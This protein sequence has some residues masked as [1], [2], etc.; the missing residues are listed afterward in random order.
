MVSK[1][2][3]GWAR[4]CGTALTGAAVACGSAQGGGST[5]W[6]PPAGFYDSVSGTG[7]AL[8]NSLFS[9]MSSGHTERAYGDFRFSAVLHDADPLAPGQVILGYDRRSVNAVWD[10]GLT[11]NR[12]HVWPQSLQPGSASN[13]TRGNLGDPHALRPMTPSVNSS[14]GN[15]PFGF[16]STIGGNRGLGS[17]YFVGDA[18]RGDIARS[19]FYSETR[20]GLING[21][22]L[23]NGLPSGNQMGDLASLVAWHYL[24]VPDAFE[25]RR[26]HVIY[27]FAEN[28]SYF[29]NNRNAYVDL[30]EV[31]WSVY[32]DQQND[33]R[34]YVGDEPEADGASVEVVLAD[35]V[36]VGAAVPAVSVPLHRDGDDGVYF[37]VTPGAGS[38]SV[39]AG[40]FNAFAIGGTD[41]TMLDIG[42]ESGATATSGLRT[43]TV[44]I[45]NLDITTGGGAGRGALDA[46]DVVFVDVLVYD[47]AEASLA[48]DADVNEI[49]FDFGEIAIGEGASSAEL[50]L[51][52]I[53]GPGELVAGLDV[54]FDSV[55]GNAGRFMTDL[56]EENDVS[57]G[58]PLPVIVTLFDD[59]AGAFEAEFVY[60]VYDD[61]FITGFV[62]GP[63]VTI[64]LTGSVGVGACPGDLTGDGVVGA[65]DLATMLSSWGQS[66]AAD[67]DGNGTIGPSDLA[68]LLA[69]W[70]ACDG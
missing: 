51:Y 31:V 35:S 58:D 37:S 18:D 61:R 41:E 60:R 8:K 65:E 39:P 38:T 68:L 6:E 44:V 48:P 30:P 49:T 2:M 47:R 5:N 63:A 11:W 10:S 32:V 3:T 36:F 29:T 53:G 56:I 23:V 52:N 40:K 62:E 66:G 21:M 13:S 15:L 24:D 46:D 28:P 19:L 64:R 34:L 54:V 50:F 45:D 7:A 70:G 9:R 1:R 17:Y 20:Y 14:R 25:R 27:S 12:E 59:Q 26:N 42:F 33:A 43:A 16:A 69:D 57:V 55:S 22:T 67:L 4:V